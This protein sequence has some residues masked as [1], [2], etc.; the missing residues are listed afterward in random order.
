MQ[1][2]EPV[3]GLELLQYE[4][5]AFTLAQM[6]DHFILSTWGPNGHPKLTNLFDAMRRVGA[7]SGRLVCVLHLQ[8]G[9]PPPDGEYRDKLVQ[10]FKD[11]KRHM[12]RFQVLAHG[13]GFWSAAN[14]AAAATFRLLG[15]GFPVFYDH[16]ETRTNAILAA[17]T[18]FDADV[19]RKAGEF[20]RWRMSAASEQ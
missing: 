5:D 2:K 13:G 10:T 12:K 17:D 3:A 16:D 6:G 11:T 9:V 7:R 20:L 4:V 8:E 19:I 1:P 15:G 18:G 14:R